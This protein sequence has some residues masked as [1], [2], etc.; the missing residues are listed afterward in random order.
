[1]GCERCREALS[2]RLDGED[3]PGAPGAV[4]AHLSRCAACRRW[5]QAA[6][7]VTDLVRASV[8]APDELPAVPVP[9][10]RRAGD[11]AV[12][13]IALR[14]A[15][16]VL[17]AVQFLLG[18]AQVAG[19]AGG[20]HLHTGG[21]GLQAGH[22]WHES[23]AWNIA[24]GAGF[25]WVAARRGRP[26]GVLPML[27][28]FVA[29]LTVLTVNDL[30]ASRVDR[31]RVASHIA[32]LAGYLII[33]VLNRRSPA[34]EPP[35]GRREPSRWKVRFD[36][37]TTADE[38]AGA[39]APPRLRLIRGLPSEA[40]AAAMFGAGVRAAGVAGAAALHGAGAGAAGIG[41]TAAMRVR[42][43][44][45]AG[46]ATMRGAGASAA[47]AAGSAAR[48]APISGAKAGPGAARVRAEGAAGTTGRRAA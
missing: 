36:D 1:M 45:A 8:P 11:E 6:T 28:A 2:A 14:W 29:A 7:Q 19:V 31:A 18:A 34:D 42:V 21:G 10:S 25:A 35:G 3:E 20:Q 27:S 38:P 23:A 46:S 22:L 4:D 39:P 48:A 37:E 17:G 13:V 16:G 15:L 44:G 12:Q 9:P 43:A 41:G 24:I 30:L 5:L 33:L 32:V 40:H 26:V 47:G